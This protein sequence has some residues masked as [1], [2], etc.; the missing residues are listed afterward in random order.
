MYAMCEYLNIL[1]IHINIGEK[2]ERITRHLC[3][4]NQKAASTTEGK[5]QKKQ[6]KHSGVDPADT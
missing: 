1:L 3:Q 6:R 5:K 4:V 2:N